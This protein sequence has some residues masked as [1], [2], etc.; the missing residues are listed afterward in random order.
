MEHTIGREMDVDWYVQRAISQTNGNLYR[1]LINR[2][3]RYPIPNCPLPR[4]TGQL[5]LDIGCNWGRWMLSA[6][7]NGYVPVGIDVKLDALQAALRVMHLHNVKG[8]VIAADLKKLPFKSDIFDAAFSYSVIQHAHKDRASSCIQEVHRV[9][10]DGG[11]SML[12]FAAKYGVGN[13]LRG[14]SR[15]NPKENDYD[16][17]CVRY[18]SIREIEALFCRIFGNFSYKPDCYF[19]LGIQRSDLDILPWRYK[20]IV[21]CS[22]ALKGL[23]HVFP[24]LERVADSV[25][26]VATKNVGSDKKASMDSLQ[27]LQDSSGKGSNLAVLDLLVCPATGGDLHFDAD[28]QE[29]VSKEAGLAYQVVDGIPVLLLDKAR[30]L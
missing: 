26:V 12:Q 17:W 22:E 30:S 19:G 18:Y 28:R 13:F 1:P 24:L 16:S 20:P 23:S 10:K 11:F 14:V 29:L 7:R 2:L 4:G 27:R 6:S 15:R 5:L 9:L 25:Y 8:Y 3:P 21:V